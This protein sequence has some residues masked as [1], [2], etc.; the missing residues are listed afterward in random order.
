MLAN[1]EVCLGFCSMFLTTVKL[2]GKRETVQ[3]DVLYS[4][5]NTGLFKIM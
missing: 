4:C 1:P 2:E 5:S 3:V